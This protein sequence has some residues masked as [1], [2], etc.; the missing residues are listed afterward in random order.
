[1]DSNLQDSNG[2]GPTTTVNPAPNDAF[3]L[4]LAREAYTESTSYFDASIRPQINAAIRQHQGVHPVGSKYH[5]DTYRGRSRLFRPKTR[6]MTRKA[7]AVAAEA[8]F[9]T[10]DV[11]TSK[12][13]DEDDPQ[14][15][16]A[17]QLMKELMEL[18]LKKS[19]PWFLTVM[20]AY[21]DSM[22]AGIVVS[23][24]YWESNRARRIDKPCVDL[25]PTENFRFSP[26]ASWIDPVS[27]SP[28]LIRRVP[29]YVKDARAKMQAGDWKQVSDAQLL[30]AASSSSDTT[31]LTRERNRQDPKQQPS[32]ISDFTI[33]WC[34][35]NLVE[36][37]G[38]DLVWWTL[39]TFALLTDPVPVQEVYAHCDGPGDRPY[40]VGYSVLE[41]HKTYPDGPVGITKDLQA[42]INE[43]TNSRVDNI[44]FAMN[45][46]FFV[47]RN[48][49]VDLRSITRNV[50]G[51]ATMMTDVNNDVKV[52]DV[53]DVTSSSFQEQDRL[54]VDFDDVAGNFS[55][56]TVQSNRRMNETVGGLQLL[57]ANTNQVGAYQ[58]R[59]FVATWVQP[60]LRQIAKMEAH[61]ET[62]E[63]ILQVAGKKA[64]LDS[65][66]NIEAID[67]ILMHQ[68]V[69]IEVDIGYGST[70]PADQI[71]NFM[72]AMNSLKSLLADGTLL[73][74]GIRVDQ[75]MKEIFGK[76]GYRDGTRFFDQQ[77]DPRITALQHQLQQMQDEMAR[78]SSPELDAAK[79]ALL[80]A[81]ADSYSAKNRQML[82]QALEAVVRS[83]FAA[84]Q[85]GQMIAAVPAIAP[86]SDTVLRT[87]AQMS[88]NEIP[89]GPVDGS[90]PSEPAAGLTQN[91]IKDPRDG[92]QFTPGASP[93][94]TSPDTPANPT[95][96][97]VT[98]SSQ[99]SQ[100]A[101]AAA[102]SP[103]AGSEA[104]IH[105]PQQ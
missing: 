58:L 49:Q 22:V 60:V 85:T 57:N 71:N 28:Y 73:N 93:G 44:K 65:D 38:Q 21:Q 31:R 13:V 100:P 35:E 89:A 33:I 98:D 88:G 103:M 4:G 63:R 25:V 54:N 17:A 27:T 50:P 80:N 96:P 82:A 51:S 2:I 23:R 76:L 45:K 48:A 91:A 18:R 47:K 42:E 84:H 34:N 105:T 52:M 30:S 83:L 20:G 95:P 11:I 90:V 7:E 67:D 86:V 69:S 9:T 72:T 46:R 74:Y 8:L 37:N 97:A 66:F 29:Y 92:I 10:T 64:K 102:A 36:V 75:V 39:D 104:G 78:K 14:N 15:V 59:T 55:A 24:Q 1:M 68:E 40:A 70:N 81:Q 99:S 26:A 87:A 32:A 61:Y 5:S 53:S 6:G 94:D 101:P 77:Q 79:A 41:T 16:A 43:I 62:D 19:I 56:S 3:Y 12:P